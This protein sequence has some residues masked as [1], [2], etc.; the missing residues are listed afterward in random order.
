MAL[1]QG[2]IYREGIGILENY[3]PNFVLLRWKVKKGC[4]LSM[5]MFDAAE[6]DVL[7]NYESMGSMSMPH[8]SGRAMCGSAIS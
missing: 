4:S 3:Y 5:K 7:R 6:I 8:G 1:V 2:P